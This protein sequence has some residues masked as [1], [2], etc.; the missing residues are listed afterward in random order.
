ML[1]DCIVCVR[2]ETHL[3]HRYPEC[4]GSDRVPARGT[5]LQWGRRALPGPGEAHSPVAAGRACSSSLRL[6]RQLPSG[7]GMMSGLSWH[8]YLWNRDQH[9]GAVKTNSGH[10]PGAAGG[11]PSAVIEGFP[12]RFFFFFLPAVHGEGAGMGLGLLPS[13]G[14]SGCLLPCVRKAR[15]QPLPFSLPFSCTSYE[16]ATAKSSCQTMPSALGHWPW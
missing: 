3:L 8:R 10:G 16:C 14:S 12:L 5:G 9:R 6:S 7:A 1:C 4:C 11:T 2:G 15:G 13:H